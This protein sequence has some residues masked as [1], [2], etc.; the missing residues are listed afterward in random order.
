MRA[1]HVFFR[2]MAV[3]LGLFCW[4]AAISI[5]SGE[6]CIAKPGT[7]TPGHCPAHGCCPKHRCCPTVCRCLPLGRCRPPLK[8]SPRGGDDDEPRGGDVPNGMFMSPPPVGTVEG[9]RRGFELPT[10]SMTLPEMTLSMPRIRFR[11][12][13]RLSQEARMHTEGG[14]APFFHAP[15]AGLPTALATA[16]GL[17]RGGDDDEGRGGDDDEDD[18]DSKRSGDDDQDS[19]K[20]S[21][22]DQKR[23]GADEKKCSQKEP[24]ET[25]P[26]QDCKCG[27]HHPGQAATSRHPASPDEVHARLRQLREQVESQHAGLRQNLKEL[28]ELEARLNDRLEPTSPVSK[29]EPLTPPKPLPDSASSRRPIYHLPPVSSSDALDRA[30]YWAPI[31]SDSLTRNSPSPARPPRMLR[32]T[33][34]RLPDIDEQ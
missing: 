17:A 28:S 21:P 30:A 6:E 8:D 11:G 10:L 12:L 33:P 29:Q 15:T 13:S 4:L 22:K 25:P 2:R 1:F 26:A 7:F 19:G 16:A 9:A 14:I 20:D 27:N 23:S 18:R 31:P 3:L 24:V 32:P 34:E 5:A